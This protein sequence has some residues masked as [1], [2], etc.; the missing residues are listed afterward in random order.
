M[1]DIMNKSEKQ[2]MVRLVVTGGGTGGHLFPG[3][4]VAEAIMAERTESE[5][6]FVGTDRQVDNQ[7]LGSRPF[8]TATLKCQGLKGKSI[9]AALDSLIQLPLALIKAIKILRSF[10]PDLVLGVGG[11]VTGPV[12]LA[13][14]LLGIPTCIHEQNSIPGLANKLL[15]KFA[16]RV[17]LSIPGSEKF[18]PKDRSLLTGNPV[19]GEILA[20][21]GNRDENNGPI[22]LVLGGSQ[23]AHRLNTLVAEGLCAFKKDFPD[24]FMVIHQT[25]SL[26]EQTIKEKYLTAG[27]KA[28]VSAFFSDMATVYNQADM[29]VSRAGAT[30]LAEICVLGKPSILIPFPFAADNHQ[31]HNGRMVVDQGGAV[32]RLES[33]LDSEVLAKDI[34]NII[35]NPEE[36]R[37]MGEK[38]RKV[39]F[40]GATELIVQE[41]LELA[42][43]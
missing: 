23:G 15:G 18:F 12:V 30:S 11:Y 26:D 22:L 14:K 6:L 7:V 17:F 38:A 8:R 20:C 41:C 34:L 40:P 31:E 3:I 42:G 29:L 32:M 4:A 25:G 36:M 33:E 10:N 5:V 13:A 16:D 43:W 9:S 2:K 35:R 27:V 39:S 19:R 21:N 1:S 37:Q 24:G 28:E